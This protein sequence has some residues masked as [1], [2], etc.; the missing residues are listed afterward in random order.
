MSDAE[1]A[2]IRANTHTGWAASSTDSPTKLDKETELDRQIVYLIQ[3][4]KDAAAAYNPDEVVAV[5][6]QSPWATGLKA[7]SD[8]H[9]TQTRR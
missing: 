6:T 8:M 1:L 9:L 4:E 7:S 2:Y 3:A 5:I